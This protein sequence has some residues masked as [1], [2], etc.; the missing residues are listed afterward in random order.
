MNNQKTAKIYDPRFARLVFSTFLQNSSTAQKLRFF[1]V[2]W[3][4]LFGKRLKEIA[5]SIT[6]ECQ[7]QCLHCCMSLFEKNRKKEL[8]VGEIKK[9]IDQLGNEVDIVYLVGGEPLVRKNDVLEIINYSAS[10]GLATSM[11]TNA[12]SLDYK[13]AKQLKDAKLNSINISLDS[14]IPEEHDRLRRHKG[15]YNAVIQAMENCRKAGLPFLISTYVTKERLKNRELIEIIKLAKEK[16]ASGVRILEPKMAGKWLENS[17]IVLDDK[18]RELF[19]ELLEPG[20]VFH[21]YKENLSGHSL[22]YSGLK[23]YIYISPYGDVQPCPLVPVSFGNIRQKDVR[24]LIKRMW[25]DKMFTKF[26]KEECRINSPEFRKKYLKK[27][28]SRMRL[29]VKVLKGKNN[30]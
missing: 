7:F 29:P 24:K 16:G 5:V 9:M 25:E 26:S 11:D 13:T 3:K 27:I 19:S 22:C 6:Y 4:K 17:K 2:A 12:F 21:E 18:D 15:S 20:F 30:D 10:K 1:R 14:S 28:S 23:G 8:S